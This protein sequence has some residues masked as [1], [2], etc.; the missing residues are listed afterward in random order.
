MR[1]IKGGGAFDPR[2]LFA[3]GGLETNSKLDWASV[4]ALDIDVPEDFK[5]SPLGEFVE[6]NSTPEAVNATSRCSNCPATSSLVCEKPLQTLL[7]AC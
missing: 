2:T 3:L 4:F 6:R 7:Q 5:L 1:S